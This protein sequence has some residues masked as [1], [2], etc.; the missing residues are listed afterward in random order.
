MGSLDG[1]SKK[2]RVRY[3]SEVKSG[4]VLP[5]R[6]IRFENSGVFIDDIYITN[7]DGKTY[8]VTVA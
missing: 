1:P 2:I 5:Y 7:E 4:T 8:V 6:D 3:Y